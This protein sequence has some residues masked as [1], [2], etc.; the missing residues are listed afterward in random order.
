[1]SI[2]KSKLLMMIEL[3]QDD[4]AQNLLEYLTS[5]FTLTR[6]ISWDDVEEV[7]PDDW[8][9]AMLNEI[10]N[11]PEEQQSYITQEQLLAE[12]GL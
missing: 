10:E 11:V 12:L 6:K 2:A 8:D 7:S 3:M 9:T 5:H 4:D 1:M